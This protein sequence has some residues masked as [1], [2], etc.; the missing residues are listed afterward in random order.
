MDDGIA[1]WMLALAISAALIPWARREQRAAAVGA[2]ALWL[3]YIVALAVAEWLLERDWRPW[4][5]AM[6]AAAVWL[7]FQPLLAVGRLTRSDV[8]LAP[9]RPG[10]AQLAFIVTAIALLLNAFIVSLRGPAAMN[11]S[12]TL[13]LAV[14][15]AAMIEELVFR[16]VLLALA[17]RAYPPR[18]NLWGAPI[19]IGGLAVT[20]AFVALHGMRPGL[21]LGVAPAAILYLWLR[22]RTDSLLAPIAAHVVWNLSVLLM[23]R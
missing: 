11:V 5:P 10:S 16:G 19:G 1:G 21:L 6:A 22:A 8:G 4:A 17:D 2:F 3:L 23:H 15:L 18:W 13:V 12:S 7:A 20:A 9:L 14:V